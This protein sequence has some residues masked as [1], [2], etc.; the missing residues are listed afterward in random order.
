[1]RNADPPEV[2][3]QRLLELRLALEAALHSLGTMHSY[4][5]PAWTCPAM[6]LLDIIGRT[7]TARPLLKTFVCTKCG[8]KTGASGLAVWVHTIED[9]GV[10]DADGHHIAIVAQRTWC[11]G[12]WEA[13]VP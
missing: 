12:P 10:K 5:L 11:Y 4:K 2:R 3:A 8:A 13:E 9:P 1:M 7:E 6:D